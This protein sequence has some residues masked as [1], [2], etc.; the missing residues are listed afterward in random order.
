MPKKLMIDGLDG[1][2]EQLI[3]QLEEQ[4]NYELGYK[5]AKNRQKRSKIGAIAATTYQPKFTRDTLISMYNSN[6]SAMNTMMGK[7][8]TTIHMPR[9]ILTTMLL[10]FGQANNTTNYEQIQ[11]HQKNR[12]QI[13]R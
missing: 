4:T 10:R 5:V 11:M 13:E 8:L 9:K 2:E 3:K 12:I 1:E 6:S 7:V